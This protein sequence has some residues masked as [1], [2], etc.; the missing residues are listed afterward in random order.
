MIKDLS[1]AKCGFGYF[2]TSSTV[3]SIK[4]PNDAKGVKVF[5]KTDDVFFNVNAD[6]GTPGDNNLVAGG[7]AAAGVLETRILQD[8]TDRTFRI[9]SEANCSVMIEF[10]G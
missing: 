10:W 4:I 1:N 9:K 3:R 8:G 5:C 2:A 6:P 7:F